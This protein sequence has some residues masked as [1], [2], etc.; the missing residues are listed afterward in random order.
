MLE[1]LRGEP[2]MLNVV[3]SGAM[4]FISDYEAFTEAG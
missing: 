2:M 1:M 4:G 3:D